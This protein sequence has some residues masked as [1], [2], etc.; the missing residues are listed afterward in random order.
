[1]WKAILALLSAITWIG[2]IVDRFPTREQRRQA[3]FQK[4]KQREREAIDRW[5]RDGGPPPGAS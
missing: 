2:R 4:A 5:I 3:A 1:M